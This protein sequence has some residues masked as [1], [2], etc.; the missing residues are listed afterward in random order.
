[1]R[2]PCA[3]AALDPPLW[4]VP[5][6]ALSGPGS[7]SLYSLSLSLSRPDGEVTVNVRSRSRPAM[8]LA[9]E[10]RLLA[11]ICRGR[12]LRLCADHFVGH[13]QL[14]VAFVDAPQTRLVR[15]ETA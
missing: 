9:R 10:G 15:I 13:E 3:G 4:I 2:S 1:M 8:V 12:H 6:K 14:L 11:D 7:L 5:N